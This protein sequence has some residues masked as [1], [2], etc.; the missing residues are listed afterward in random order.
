[1]FVCVCHAITEQDVRDATRGAGYRSAARYLDDAG[2]VPEC[3][4]CVCDIHD[5]VRA[6]ADESAPAAVPHLR[7]AG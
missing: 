1:M 2:I 4:K 7:L 6:E 5:I 3:G